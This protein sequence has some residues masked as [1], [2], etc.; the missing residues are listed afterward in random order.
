MRSPYGW[1]KTAGRG[2]AYT[3][4]RGRYWIVKVGSQWHLIQMGSKVEGREQQTLGRFPTMTAA[5]D[6][7][8]TEVTA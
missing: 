1:I 7:F 6:Y 5:A 4:R 2:S 3:T 8:K